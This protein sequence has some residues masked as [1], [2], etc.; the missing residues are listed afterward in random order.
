MFDE[1]AL[2]PRVEDQARSQAG[3]QIS[4][5]HGLH[6]CKKTMLRHAFYATLEVMSD[7]FLCPSA[8]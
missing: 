8:M 3:A 2:N 5:T 7:L 1:L 6:N 4:T